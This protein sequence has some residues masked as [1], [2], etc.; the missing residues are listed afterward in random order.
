[1]KITKVM[2]MLTILSMRDALYR[3]ISVFSVFAASSGVR[4]YFCSPLSG[5]PK[6]Y[7]IRGSCSPAEDLAAG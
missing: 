4:K 5:P 3:E 1:M 6:S 7:D 2:K